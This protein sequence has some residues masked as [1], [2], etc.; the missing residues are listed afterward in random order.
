MESEFL[1]QLCELLAVLG[2]RVVR[3]EFPYM[4]KMR[5][6]G[7]RRLP[8]RQEKL[9]ECW[10][11]VWQQVQVLEPGDWAVG[12]K[13]MGGR[14]AS[15]LAD[16][17]QA[18]ALVCLGYPF[19]PSG[20]PERLR[21]EH[22]QAL[23]TSALI[24]QGERDAFGWRQEVVNYSLSESIRLYWLAGGDHDFQPLK[25]SGLTRSAHLRAAAQQIAEFLAAARA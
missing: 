5:A 7:G 14:I 10:R 15:L 23:K 18:A 13:S 2:V 6:D 1:Q 8:D 24:I 16:E 12:G 17:L 25:S 11:A 3:F 22:L 4:Q 21:V 19:H 9:Q 20:K